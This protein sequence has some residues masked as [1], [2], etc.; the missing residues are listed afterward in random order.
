VS[1]PEYQLQNIFL[2]GMMKTGEKVIKERFLDLETPVI[3]VKVPPSS[4]S[5]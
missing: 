5:N 3:S 2:G 4:D 1:K